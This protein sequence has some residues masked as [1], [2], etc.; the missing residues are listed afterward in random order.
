M[1]TV[2]IWIATPSGELVDRF[3]R[4]HLCQFL[5]AGNQNKKGNTMAESVAFE[6]DT[7]GLESNVRFLASFVD[8]E[9][10]DT[11][12]PTNYVGHVSVI[13]DEEQYDEI[14]FIIHDMED[15]AQD[16]GFAVRWDNGVFVFN[17][18]DLED[19]E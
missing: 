12:N 3:W 4:N 14:D 11:D 5:L 15:K 10:A 8:T 6:T 7:F 19:E 16:L 2:A 1:R 13:Y 18:D 9:T 17:S